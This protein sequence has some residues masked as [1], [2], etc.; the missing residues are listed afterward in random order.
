MFECIEIKDHPQYL[1]QLK[2]L[3]EEYGRYLFEELGLAAGRDS[4]Y[5]EITSLPGKLY[6][7][8][9]GTFISVFS[10][11]EAVGCVGIKKWDDQR[12]ELKRMYIHP[13]ARGKGAGMQL[14]RY[15]VDRSR[16]L[17][18]KKIL[19]DTNEVME[20]AVRLYLKTGFVFIDPYCINENKHPLFM[21][22]A[23]AI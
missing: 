7:P 17:G 13:S 10:E 8:P 3:L 11:M 5:K 20:K 1:P 6:E 22:Y 2:N 19:L 16:Q 14:C 23:H 21:E 4:F 12:C 15:A 9:C 18:Y